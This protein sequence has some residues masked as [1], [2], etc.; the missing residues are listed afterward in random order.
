MP[1]YEH[2]AA[3]F[4]EHIRTLAAKEENLNNLESYLSYCFPEWL[5]KYASTMEDLTSELGQFAN[6][7]V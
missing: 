1:K 2:I 5:K 3:Q 6:M 7:E 4:C